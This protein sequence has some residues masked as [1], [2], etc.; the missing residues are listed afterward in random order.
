M[1]IQIA[2]VCEFTGAMLAMEALDLVVAVHVASKV[3]SERENLATNLA[4]KTRIVHVA[5]SHMSCQVIR[6]SVPGAALLTAPGLVLRL[7]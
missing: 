5:F 1:L 2:F 4:T 3:V 7:K 6:V